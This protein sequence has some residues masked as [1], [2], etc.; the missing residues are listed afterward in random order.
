M[1]NRLGIVRAGGGVLLDH[2]NVYVCIDALFPAC[3]LTSSS[4]DNVGT[5]NSLLPCGQEGA[6]PPLK[7]RNLMEEPDTLNKRPALAPLAPRRRTNV[8]KLTADRSQQDKGNR[9]QNYD[10]SGTHLAV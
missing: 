7:L 1:K 10:A 4:N 2:P 5:A 3:I 6:G 8:S 9:E